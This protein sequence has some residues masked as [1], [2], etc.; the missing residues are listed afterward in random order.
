MG[1][2]TK[3]SMIATVS[4]A[5]I[6]LEESL[7]TLEYAH[8]ARRITNK[9]EINQKL[10]KRAVIKQYSDEIER[11]KKDLAAQREQKGIFV[12][13]DNYELVHFKFL[14]Y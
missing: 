1:G 3:T 4:P 6:N 5:S 8:R 14:L 9:P 11:L 7:S 13:K 2:R 12:S 10:T